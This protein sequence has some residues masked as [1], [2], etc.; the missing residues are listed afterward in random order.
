MG[1]ATKKS[2]PLAGYRVLEMGSTISGPFCGRLLADFGAEV[3]KVEPLEG[4]PLRKKGR[5]YHD[6]SLYAATIFRN[7]STIAVNLRTQEGQEVIKKLA[8]HCDIVVENF[9][10]GALEKW[11]IGYEHL[12]AINPGIVMIRISGYGQTGPYSQ[13]GGFGIICEGVGGLRNMTGDPDRPPSRVAVSL[14]DCLTAVY[15]CFGAMMALLH[16][17]KTGEGQVIDAA[18]YESAFSFMEPHVT[19]YDKLGVVAKRSGTTHSHSVVNNTFATKDQQFIHI[20]ASS[21]YV[22]PRLAKAIGRPD[23]LDD[24]RYA[25]AIARTQHADELD[26]IV[27]RWVAQYDMGEAQRLLH[28][29]DVPAMGIYT[30][31]DIFTDPHF[32]ARNMLVEVP[33]PE[34][35]TVTVPGVVPKLSKTPGSVRHTGHRIGED[36]RAV[37]MKIAGMTKKEVDTLTAAGVVACRKPSEKESA[38]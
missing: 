20:A 25:K 13:F 9:R 2:G 30:M 19:A 23:L 31:A 36:T 8:S 10:P 7:K 32:R 38:A 1:D 22:F 17:E 15:A 33:D 29:S 4:D 12:S 3:I 6:V 24:E 26:D 18:L 5:H 28:E 11:G 16:R 21:D 27:A 34:L 35:G 37:L 14:T